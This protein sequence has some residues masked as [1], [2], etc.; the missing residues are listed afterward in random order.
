MG[1]D[2]TIRSIP[3]TLALSEVDHPLEDRQGKGNRA[4]P[5]SEGDGGV[6]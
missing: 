4:T 6:T 5:P 3:L 1:E 2:T